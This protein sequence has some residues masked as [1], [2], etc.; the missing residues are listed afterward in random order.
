MPHAPYVAPCRPLQLSMK[1]ARSKELAFFNGEDAYKDLQN[2]GAWA[3]RGHLA[4][5]GSEMT[6]IHLLQSF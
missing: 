3:M 5:E 6:A 2:K 4:L 1:E